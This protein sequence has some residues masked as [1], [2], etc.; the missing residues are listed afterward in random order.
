MT[1]HP[2]KNSPAIRRWRTMAERLA[3][4]SAL[5]A[6]H[7]YTEQARAAMALARDL[8]LLANSWASLDPET[9][10]EEEPRPHAGHENA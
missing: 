4:D 9:A 10:M 5:M 1:F 3:M 2:N 8:R 7:G 6:K